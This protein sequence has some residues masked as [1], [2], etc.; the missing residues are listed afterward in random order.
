M[1]THMSACLVRYQ[2]CIREILDTYTELK[3]S[4]N[5]FCLAFLG[6]V[7]D[8]HKQ[9]QSKPSIWPI[10]IGG[11]YSM[12]PFRANHMLIIVFVMG[13]DQIWIISLARTSW[14]KLTKYFRTCPKHVFSPTLV[15]CQA[16][17]F[18]L[19]LVQKNPNSTYRLA[20]LGEFLSHIMH[21]I[22]PF[23]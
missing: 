22:Y 9:Y 7:L 13:F 23:S 14:L 21:S 19:C 4:N 3:N 1:I 15:M 12:A 20:F 10:W 16:I 8:C 11:Y 6:E 5:I 18:G 17:L 2:L